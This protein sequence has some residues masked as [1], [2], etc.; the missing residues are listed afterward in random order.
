MCAEGVYLLRRDVISI[1]WDTC[2]LVLRE[3]TVAVTAT[4]THAYTV[5]MEAIKDRG[6]VL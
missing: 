1:F 2:L 6:K 3:Y 5:M 4:D